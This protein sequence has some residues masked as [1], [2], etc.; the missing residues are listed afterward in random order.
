M[1]VRWISTA[2]VALALFTTAAPALLTITPCTGA[3]SGGSALHYPENPSFY[4]KTATTGTITTSGR[5][6]F[7]WIQISDMHINMHEAPERRANFDKFCNETVDV[8]DPAFVLATGDL[9]DASR[10]PHGYFHQDVNEYLFYNQTLA[11]YGRNGTFWFPVVG[12]HERYGTGLNWTLWETYIRNETQYAFDYVAPFGKYRFVI[13]D[14]T[15]EVGSIRHLFGYW[16]EAKREK[17]DH[18]ERLLP[19]DTDDFDGVILV[20]HHPINQV[21]SEKSSS[22]YTFKEIMARSG[23]PVYLCGHLHLNDDYQDHGII[24]ELEAPAFKDHYYYRVCAIDDG[25]FSFTEA[26]LDQWPAVVVTTP[27][28][29]RF[30]N[31]KMPLD[32]LADHNEIRTLVFDPGVVTSAYAE[33]DGKVVGNLTDRGNHLWSVPFNTQAYLDGRHTLKIHVSTSSGSVVKELEFQATYPG[34]VL[35]FSWSRVTLWT[36]V[37]AGLVAFILIFAIISFSHVLVPKLYKFLAKRR[38]WDSKAPRRFEGSEATFFQRHLTK[39]WVQ[40]ATLPNYLAVPLLVLPLYILVGPLFIGE[41]VEGG[42]GVLWLYRT[43]ILGTYNLDVFGL[44]FG[45]ILLVMSYAV[46][47]YV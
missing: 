45:W 34:K 28:D 13:L 47:M 6:V 25:I 44:I 23:A 9:V 30:V 12:N 18:L 27:V 24:H 8:V 41:L 3:G 15:L 38:D 39:R 29:L 35:G 26:Q 20:G 32:R 16:G 40:A 2:F 21:Y 31:E 46:A 7:Y 22:G 1:R 33:V 37:I 5:R 10:S 43:T 4:Q 11:K 36:P 42:F 19:K 17:L 14:T